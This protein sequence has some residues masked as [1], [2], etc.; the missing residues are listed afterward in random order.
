[1]TKFSIIIAVRTVTDFL[2]E[3][4]AHFSNLDYPE[5]E[6][7]II[8]D[9]PLAQTLSSSAKFI[10]LMS[11]GDGNPSLKRNIGA[12]NAS[13]NVLVFLDDDA[14][15]TV[16]W[17]SNAALIFEDSQVYALGGPAM[18]PP[19]VS[20]SERASGYVLQSFLAS[21]NTS[22]RHKPQ[23]SR[24]IADYPTVNLFV[25][26]DIFDQIGGFGLEFWPGE[27]TKLC[28]D[29]VTKMGRKFLYS[30]DPVV[31]HH[32]RTLFKPHLTQI[33][34]YGKHRGQYARIF[35]E[36]SRLPAYF[37]P[38]L[39]LLGL[40]FGPLSFFISPWLS[41]MYLIILATYFI[42]LILESARYAITEKSVKIFYYV[43]LGIFLTHVVYGFNFIVGLL[44][45]PKLKLKAVDTKSGNYSEG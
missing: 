37:I 7:L 39:F 11:N 38:S 34:R 12:K 26:K 35:P 17:L 15:P 27:D 1:M 13:G 2:K 42:L 18:T 44:I 16:S 40:F 32:R 43:S 28:L 19:D 14:Y 45:R 22:Y 31:Y 24:L 10:W 25:R 20:M 8:T 3:S 9:N 29:L 5:F 33:S 30:P 4:I 21:G 41:L 36:S 23:S 6:V